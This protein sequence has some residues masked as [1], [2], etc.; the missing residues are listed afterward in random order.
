MASAKTQYLSQH[1]FMGAIIENICFLV[2]MLLA[3][4]MVFPLVSNVF[5]NNDRV[6]MVVSGHSMDPTLYDGEMIFANSRVVPVRGDIL[7]TF[8]PET[9]GSYAG[10][11]VVKRVIGLPGD[12]VKINSDNTVWINGEKLDE[13]Y[14]SAEAAAKTCRGNYTNVQLGDDEYFIMGDNRGNSYDSRFF[15]ALNKQYIR[16]VYDIENV[17]SL[18]SI[19]LE[20][21]VRVAIVFILWLFVNCAAPNII[22]WYLYKKECQRKDCQE[23]TN[24][25]VL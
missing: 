4:V 2:A 20:L 11:T 3:I 5:I 15:G 13:P 24:T 23:G 17:T 22:Y 14:L 8:M 19:V 1:K 25:Q 9:S 21:A 18:N 7:L 10:N 6:T 12:N 16:G